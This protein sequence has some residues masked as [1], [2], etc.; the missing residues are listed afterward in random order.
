M[1]FHICHVRAQSLDT[2]EITNLPDDENGLF[3]NGNGTIEG[4]RHS[5]LRMGFLRIKA[6]MVSSR[7]D[8]M[9]AG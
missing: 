3:R 8:G 2:C 6:Y 9:I 5:L 4:K 1:D 7:R